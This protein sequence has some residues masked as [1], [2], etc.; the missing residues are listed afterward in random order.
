V[1]EQAGV[2]ADGHDSLL[3]ITGKPGEDAADL[4]RGPAAYP[5][6]RH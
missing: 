1:V 5:A 4:R 3:D 2:G 6:A